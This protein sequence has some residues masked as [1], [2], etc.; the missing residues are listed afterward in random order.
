MAGIFSELQ[1]LAIDMTKTSL[2]HRANG[3]HHSRSNGK[4]H[5]AQSEKKAKGAFYTSDDIASY[6]V[7]RVVGETSQKILEPSFGDGSFIEAIT[8]YYTK[9]K[10]AGKL[11]ENVYGIE[12]QEGA[13]GQYR[14]NWLFDPTKI[15]LSD[16]IAVEPFPV[17]VVIGNPP[18]VGLNKL[19]P[20]EYQRAQRLID[21]YNFKMQASGS[22]WFPFVLHA[23]AFLKQGGAM[24][25][26][27]PFEVTYVRYAK[28]LWKFLGER[29]AELTVVRV[30]EDIF[31]D[32]DVETVLLIAKGYGE[33]TNFANYEIYPN[34]QSLLS[35][36][37]QKIK[38]VAVNSTLNGERPF[39]AN[40]LSQEHLDIIDKL[41]A[42]GI[43]RPIRQVCKFKIGYVCADNQYFHPSAETINRFGIPDDEL[44]PA[45]AN[46]KA[47]KSD[48]GLF[49]KSGQ[50][51]TR[52]FYPN[53]QNLT[54]ETLKYIDYG[55]SSR[56]N[57]RYKCRQRTPWYVT[58]GIEIPDIILTVFG[59]K[60]K[61]YV[62]SGR[63]LASNSLL[64]GFMQNR[65]ITSRQ[66]AASW[67]N[68]LTLLSIELKV[69]SLGGGVL[70]FIPGETDAIEIVDPGTVG[71]V[72]KE[73]YGEVDRL[74][75]HGELE[76][77]YLVG[78][79][80]ILKRLGL[81]SDEIES[82]RSAVQ[83]LRRWRNAKLRKTLERIE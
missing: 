42:Q 23:C 44:L 32:V 52:L 79:E 82:L 56:V 38:S 34:R 43:I 17:D 29:F 81:S 18:Y 2:P 80:Y 30:F 58:P 61:L 39:V 77:A 75:K 57:D 12:V 35:G 10:M 63:Y 66:L 45:I 4:Y 69:H 70:I 36:Q 53:A 25:F 11:K 16:F 68:T 83:A 71:N 59:D 7:N 74:L 73:F 19:P 8:R 6:L 1:S 65:Q 51:T 76:K 21:S 46:A 27:L 67:Y 14:N 28:Q 60:P 22:L 9:H 55:K 72:E 54:S 33:S 5:S 26:V 48:V 13:I 78:D 64:C 49:I 24:A 41:R 15:I 62:N 40:L 3:K 37:A 31:P 47:I 50:V 20:D